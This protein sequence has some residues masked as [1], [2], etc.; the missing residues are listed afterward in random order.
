MSRPQ[1]FLPYYTTHKFRIADHRLHQVFS[2]TKFEGSR[3]L[4]LSVRGPPNHPPFVPSRK[5]RIAA[6][7]NLSSATY[8][9][10]YLVFPPNQPTPRRLEIYKNLG[11]G[12]GNEG[13]GWSQVGFE[14]GAILAAAHYLCTYI[15]RSPFWSH[16]P[17][18]ASENEQQQRLSFYLPTLQDHQRELQVPTTASTDGRVN[19]VFN[20][21]RQ[22]AAVAVPSASTLFRMHENGVSLKLM[23][24]SQPQVKI[25]PE[26]EQMEASNGARCPVVSLGKDMHFVLVD[27]SK[28]PHMLTA[29]GTSPAA[30]KLL[31]EHFT[32]DVEPGWGASAFK[33]G[34][35]GSVWYVR[36]KKD[37]MKGEAT[38]ENLR[39]RAFGDICAWEEEGL[40][41]AAAA[42]GGWLSV[43]GTD[44][45]ENSASAEGL[46]EGVKALKVEDSSK[47]AESGAEVRPTQSA[48]D[49]VERKVFG[50]QMGVEIGR[51][52]TIA[53]EVDV[54]VD[55]GG[56]RRLGGMVVSGRAN[57]ETKGELLGA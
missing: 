3:H 22:V 5:A 9:Y 40:G 1:C 50:I 53:V 28:A 4:V 56:K 41:S 21:Y 34:L 20:P 37:E 24:D 7:F 12:K 57:F 47:D 33:S 55:K 36:G 11:D 27:V 43:A 31:D 49:R 44:R 54:L 25:V 30:T 52:S 23:L 39:C 14:P 13:Y 45:A 10:D 51:N 17:R 16:L 38:I 42:L 26:L 8:I 46:A 18:G 48:K 29:L 19:V 15:D 6:E 35:V 2:P 32:P